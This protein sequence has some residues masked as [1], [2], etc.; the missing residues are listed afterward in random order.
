M[1]PLSK[2]LKEAILTMPQAE[3]DKL[4][5]RLVAKDEDLC[6]QLEYKLIDEQSSLESRREEVRETIDRVVR[7]SHYSPGWLMMDLRS[8]NATITHHVK[9]TK[10]K[11][12]ELELTLY[13]LNQVFEHQFPFIEKHTSKSETLAVYVAKRTQFV[14]QKLSKLHPD[15]HIE[16]E[17]DMKRLLERVHTYASSSY[18]KELKIPKKLD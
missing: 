8:V 7:G 17:E 11:Y 14:V 5:L 15:L 6:Q 10:D 16:F 3:K 4:L 18:A 12:G 2:E 1:P 9:I 13:M